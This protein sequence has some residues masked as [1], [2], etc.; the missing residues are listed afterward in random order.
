VDA[1]RSRSKFITKVL[2]LLSSSGL[3]EFRQL[4]IN[5][6]HL[7]HLLFSGQLGE[8]ALNPQLME[9]L[10]APEKMANLMFL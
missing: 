4:V 8:F 2:A 5:I 7:V 6:N 1:Q 10:T 9:N 3:L